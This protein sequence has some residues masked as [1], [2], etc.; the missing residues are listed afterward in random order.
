MVDLPNERSLQRLISTNQESVSIFI[1]LY[2][3]CRLA[4]LVCLHADVT[5][6][7]SESIEQLNNSVT[8]DKYQGVGS[9]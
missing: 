5:K 2:Y 1:E 3:I 7:A 9:L 6:L 4:L 8:M